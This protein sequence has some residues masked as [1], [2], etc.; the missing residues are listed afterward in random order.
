MK[1]RKADPIEKAF[2][3]A[4]NHPISSKEI[5]ANNEVFKNTKYFWDLDIA[6]LHLTYD[7][8]CAFEENYPGVVTGRGENSRR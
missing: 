3:M 8:P 2:E 1:N 7:A 5:A 4:M 6:T